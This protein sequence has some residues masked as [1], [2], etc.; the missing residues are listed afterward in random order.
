MTPEEFEAPP[1]RRP[2]QELVDASAWY[3]G[4]SEEDRARR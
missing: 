4:P 1:G 2:R 3:R